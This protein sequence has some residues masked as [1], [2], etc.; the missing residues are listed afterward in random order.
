MK[1]TRS[2]RCTGARLMHICVIYTQHTNTTHTF[3]FF[4]S[5]YL[6][7]KLETRRSFSR[8]HFKETHRKAPHITFL[9]RRLVSALKHGFR[10]LH[11]STCILQY[12][13]PNI[14]HVIDQSSILKMIIPAISTREFTI[15]KLMTIHESQCT[16]LA[17]E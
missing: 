12:T 14:M 16:R 2:F 10:I 17:K 15:K 9:L 3:T 1:S 5:I 6:H 7:A 11:V 4:G 13:I 8:L